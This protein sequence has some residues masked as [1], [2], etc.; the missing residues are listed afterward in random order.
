M[1]RR[2]YFINMRN[3]K[4]ISAIGAIALTLGVGMNLQY[5]LDDYGVKT[6]SLSNFVWA[7]SRSSGGGYTGAT[8]YGKESIVQ[9]VTCEKTITTTT[10][11]GNSSSISGGISGGFGGVS[12]G[13]SGSTG[14]ESGSSTTTEIKETYKANK[15][16]CRDSNVSVLICSPVSPCV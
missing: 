16:W 14:S 1:Y 13:V 12:A 8:E 6:N 11:S 9:Q 15:I 10:S 5:S 7:Q 3:K 2:K 4:I